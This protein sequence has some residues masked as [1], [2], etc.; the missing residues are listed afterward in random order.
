MLKHRGDTNMGLREIRKR[1][2]LTQTRL[3]KLTGLSQPTIAQYENGTMNPNRT[4]LLT[5]RKLC[6]ALSCSPWDL[7]EQDEAPYA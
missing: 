2:G 4:T 6:D 5:A 7:L 3:A 1:E